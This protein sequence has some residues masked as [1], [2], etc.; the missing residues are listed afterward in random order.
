M[1]LLSFLIILVSIIFF[2]VGIDLFKRK[3]FNILHLIIFLGG[4]I[5]LIVFTLN[6]TLL[7]KFGHIFWLTRGADLI[8]Y[9]SIVILMYFYLSLLN[10]ISRMEIKDTALVREFS[11]NNAQ[12]DLWDCDTVFVIPAYNE[13]EA[14]IPV[15]GKI[16]EAGYGVIFIDDGKNGNLIEKLHQTYSWKALITIKHVMNL[17][18][19]GALETGSEYIRRF[20]EKIQ[21]VVH[22]DADGQHRLEDLPQFQ[23]AFQKNPDLEIVLGS[24][25]LWNTVNMPKTKRIVLKLWILFTRIFSGIKL[26]DTHN[27]YRMMRKETLDKIHITMNK[28]EHASEIIDLIKSQKLKYQEVPITVLYTEHSL[29]KGQKIWNAFNIARNLLYKK[30]F[31]R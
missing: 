7:N 13:Q 24:R 11:L 22:F 23:Q 21:Y 2:F 10:R 3:K 9:A 16:L 30:I 5:M 1:N 14:P 28:M 17:G 4:T 29:Q 26:T 6:G 18:Q 31:F 15:I 20:W 8:V 27:G 19:G 12:G 25:F